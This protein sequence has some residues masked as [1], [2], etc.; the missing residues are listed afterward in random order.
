MNESKTCELC[1]YWKYFYH[2]FDNDN[3]KYSWGE[4]MNEDVSYRFTPS[5][6]VRECFEGK[7]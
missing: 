1:K 7:A 5:S 6:W 3:K 4:C 2:V